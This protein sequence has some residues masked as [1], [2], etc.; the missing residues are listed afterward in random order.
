MGRTIE[1]LYLE[2]FGCES[3]TALPISGSGS[4]RRYYRLSSPAGCA[5]G[6]KGTDPDEN[7]AFIYLAGHF[8]KKEIN[9][10]EILAVADGG[11]EY[12]QEDLG[13]TSLFDKVA[14]GRNSGNYGEEETDFL[15]AAL[16]ELPKIQFIGAQ[17]LDYSICYPDREFNARMVD[18][19]LNYFKYCFLKLSG[20]EFNEI[21]LQNDF[22]RLK[23]D[24]LEDFGKTFMYRDFQARNIMWHKDSPWFIDFQ[25]G[26]RGPIFYDAV[27]FIWQAGS[28]FPKEMKARLE[29]CYMTALK[30]FATIKES[31]FRSRMH[32]FA[33]FRVMQVLG[34]YGFRG[35]FERKAHFLSS[36][37]FAID[38]LGQLL[39]EPLKKYPYLEKVLRELIIRESGEPR[40]ETEGL[41]VEVMSFSYRKG[42]PED[43]SIHGGGYVFDCRALNNPGRYD[44]FKG[45]SGLDPEVAEFLVGNS[46]TE[47]FLNEIYA[48][49]DR[50]VRVFLG[51]GFKHLR[52]CFG[53]TGGRH[54]SV[55]CAEKMAEHIHSAFGVRVSLHHRELGIKRT[56][57]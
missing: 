15:C 4:H 51:R 11:M 37:P 21:W 16:S 52:I 10:P 1:E 17:D 2:R 6:V 41:E 55:Y 19:D 54:R 35:R 12:L 20:I 53:C 9:V 45:L 48:P 32:I 39:E 14:E 42:V 22:D 25:G 33:L 38:N 26:R 40:D 28:H 3:E 23:N 46:D 57:E 30:R 31:I 44:R 47:A 36:I 49:V 18:F 8:R 29:D 50:H 13:E 5:I 7:K 27:S 24:L 56:L 43:R 34:A